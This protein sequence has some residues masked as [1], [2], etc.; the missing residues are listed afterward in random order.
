MQMSFRWYGEEDPVS[1]DYIRQIP[2][3]KGIVSAIYDIP[4]GES[5]PLEKILELKQTIAKHDLELAVI[6]SVPVHEDIKLGKSTRTKYIENYKTTL[7]NLGEAGIPVVC[8][9]FMPVF[10]WTRSDLSYALDDGSRTLIFDEE[11]VSKM[12]PR[13]LSL[14]GWDESYTKEEMKHLLDDYKK[15]DEEQLWENLSFFI[16]EILPVAEKAKVKMAMHPDDPPYS[17]FGLP[18]II[19]DKQALNRLVNLYD[20]PYNGVTLCVGSFASDPKNDAVEILIEMLE[21]GRV[22]FMHTRNVKLVG[23]KSFQES[24]HLSQAGSIDMYQVIKALVNHNYTGPLRP[25]HGRM[26]WGEEGKPGY[27]LYDRALGATYFNGLYE[28]CLK[29]NG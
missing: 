8:Y 22:N 20:S 7:I 26:I 21:K 4:V 1:L 19:T 11:A 12:D 17:I 16:K 27:G 9:N 6:E 25:D 15:I 3:M 13:T 2:N 23:G 10:D 29:A 14:P 5:W 28:A 18:R 24:A